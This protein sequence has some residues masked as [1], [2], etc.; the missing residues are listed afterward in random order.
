[1]GKEDVWLGVPFH[2]LHEYT[3]YDAQAFMSAGYVGS[4]DMICVLA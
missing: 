2:M 4:E 1:M 3:V